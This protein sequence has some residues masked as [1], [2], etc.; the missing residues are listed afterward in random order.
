VARLVSLP[1]EKLQATKGWT[2]SELFTPAE[3]TLMA[4]D[5]LLSRNQVKDATFCGLEAPF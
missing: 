5:E 3:R 1:E 2:T 4:A